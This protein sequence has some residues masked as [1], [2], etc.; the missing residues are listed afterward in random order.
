VS[1]TKKIGQL[2]FVGIPGPEI[3][4][5]IED[6]LVDLSPGGII[7]FT[8]NYESPEQL[9]RL[10]NKIQKLSLK[11]SWGNLPCFIGVDQEGGRV[12]RFKE[13][14][15]QFPPQQDWAEID[16]AKTS[17]EIAYVMAKELSSV[18]VNLNFAPVLDVLHDNT[19]D[20][21]G[22]RCF[23]ASP[24]E[25]ALHGSAVTRGLAKGGVIAVGK[26][27]PGH[28]SVDVDSHI[29]LPESIKSLEDLRN[30][31]WVP[32]RRAIKS[33]VDGIMIAHLLNKN[34]DEKNMA[35]FSPQVIQN[36]LRNELRFNKL[37]FSDDLEMGALVK[38]TTMKE[39]ALM[40]VACGVDQILVCKEWQ[41]VLEIRDLLVE[42][43]KREILSMDLLEQSLTRIKE[44]K[45]R[46]LVPYRSSDAKTAS[47]ILGNTDFKKVLDLVKDGL[48]VEEGPSSVEKDS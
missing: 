25:V 32:F 18:G 19:T 40:A 21:L 8:R 4:P 44:V 34:L 14:F 27:F 3:T 20:I 6:F 35:T 12:I 16:S 11:H 46:S 10:T 7:L 9:V 42:T 43:F 24:E 48:A 17:F 28:G 2:F 41:K 31:D 5:E 39:G 33:K 23:S 13:P 36:H 15:S 38:N 1:L 29:D 47:A 45:A 26:H 37:V 30:E 22:D